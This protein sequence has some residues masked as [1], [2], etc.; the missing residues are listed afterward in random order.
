MTNPSPVLRQGRRIGLAAA[1]GI[2]LISLCLGCG[3]MIGLFQV[4]P[5]AGWPIGYVVDACVGVETTGRWQV[6]VWWIAPWL[7]SM[8][9]VY[10]P[11]HYCIWLPWL[12]ILPLRGG[13]AIPP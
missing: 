4:A 3:V 6:G 5:T 7:S 2:G 11:Q 10:L 8:P 9:P 12:P 1:A 13:L